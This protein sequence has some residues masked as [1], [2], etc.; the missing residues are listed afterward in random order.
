MIVSAV[1][2]TGGESRR[3]GQ[4][5]ALFPWNGTPLWNH[6][7][8]ILRG[9][10]PEEIMISARIDPPWRPT[11]TSFVADA[12]PSCG[13]A[14]GLS[15][16]LAVMKGSHLIALAV[17]M[18]SMTQ[19]YLLSL[20]EQVTPGCG[21]VPILNGSPEPLAAVY[22][23]EAAATVA[24]V[25]EEKSNLSLRSVIATLLL[26]KQMRQIPVPPNELTLFQNVNRP[27]DIVSAS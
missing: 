23:H 3:F 2:L 7:L 25:I 15:A 16:A 1:L 19:N 26:A 10:S 11:D 4:D 13:P 27:T 12:V 14:G 22:P 5:K 18:P 8:A 20:L 21:V 17:D 24:K 6:Q 9:T